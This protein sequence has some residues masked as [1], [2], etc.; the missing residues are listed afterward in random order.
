MESSISVHTQH[1]GRVKLSQPNVLQRFAELSAV[2]VAHS[3]T[4]HVSRGKV[5]HAEDKNTIGWDTQRSSLKRV[6]SN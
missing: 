6:A 5:A 4:Q 2:F 1:L 3:T